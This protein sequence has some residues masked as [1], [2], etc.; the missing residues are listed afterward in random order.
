[1]VLITGI[2]I[3]KLVKDGLI[4]RRNTK[5]HSR[6]RAR[7]KKERVRKGRHTGPGCRKGTREA[8]MPTSILWMRRQ[9]VLRRLLRKFR[10]Q[11]KIDKHLYHK[12]YLASK[13]NQFKNKKVL[14][15]AIYK[16]KTGKVKEE[17]LAEQQE[18]RRKR[19]AEKRARKANRRA[20]RAEAH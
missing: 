1:V 3:R 6:T 9:R 10:T 2:S 16:E 18:L 5:I 7:L 12:F 4:Y 14:I 11:K 19:N 15:E 20:G 17:R 13:G 8:R